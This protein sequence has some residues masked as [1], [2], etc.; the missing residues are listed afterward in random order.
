MSG[1]PRR[2]TFAFVLMAGA[3]LFPAGARPSAEPPICVVVDPVVAIG[4]REAG[5]NG[6]QQASGG[7]SPRT[8]PEAAR[9]DETVSGS[10]T[11]VEHDPAHIGVIVVPGTARRVLRVAFARARVQVERAIPPIHSYLVRVAP[12]R[13]AAAVRALRASH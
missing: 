5:K 6:Q 7:E 10:P 8:S 11:T 3:T 2:A 13:Q 1:V 12:A 4:C 9:L